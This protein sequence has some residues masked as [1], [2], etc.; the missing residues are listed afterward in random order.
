MNEGRDVAILALMLVA[1]ACLVIFFL[2]L[3]Q[4][5]GAIVEWLLSSR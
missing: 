3:P 2:G 4:P 5:S 1:T